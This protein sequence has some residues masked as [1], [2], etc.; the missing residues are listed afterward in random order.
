MLLS[1]LWASGDERTRFMREARAIAG[2]RH[3]H[4]VQVYDVGELDG[5][6]YFTMEFLE[7]GNLRQKQA[8]KPQPA[9]QAA[10]LVALLATAMQV[11]HQS[12]VVHRDL[13]PSNILLTEDGTPKI[14]DFGLARNINAE[15]ED[16]VTQSGVRVGT[17]NYMAPEQALGAHSIGPAA[18]IYALGAILY[19][20]L[21]GR[22]PFQGATSV[23]TISQTLLHEP[24]PP[25]RLIPRLPRDLDTICLK[26]LQKLPE[27]RYLTS[28]DLAADLE[29]FLRDEPI[30]A[31][32]IGKAEKLLRW[33]MRHK[34]IAAA[35]AAVLLLLV[36]IAVGSLIAAGHFKTMGVVQH[37]LA[38]EKGE[39]AEKESRERLKAVE[40]ESRETTLRK[41][42]ESQSEELRHNLYL[43]HM[44][45][46]GQASRAPS[47]IGRI[48]E[49]LAPWQNS[50][51]DL[52]GWEWYYLD[53][54]C[55]RDL[56]TL[57][58]HIGDVIHVCWSPD[59]GR[60]ATSSGDGTVK[61]WNATEGRRLLNIDAHDG[62]AYMVAWSPNGQRLAT[63]GWDRTVKIWDA[64]SGAIQYTF[65]SHAGR[66]FSVAW[67]PDGA[68]LASGDDTGTIL[69]WEAAT[70]KSVAERSAKARNGIGSAIRSSESTR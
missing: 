8:G 13:K 47:G 24:V 25:V 22:P 66:A 27:R 62:A 68:R 65:R 32:P 30:L 18:D 4:I 40:A 26:C 54:L 41:L 31:R 7:G 57:Q 42:A 70:G 43:A 39:L 49:R 2:L 16:G 21:T 34:A 15:E 12:G 61:I 6:P 1:G 23:E 63:A 51:P 52:R 53:S 19:E 33:T 11:A 20:L 67:S 17:P 37:R 48:R 9:R 64:A 5:C 36:T 55:H 10:S 44:N 59:S 58:G 29:R 69:V 35:L 45:L 56:L 60:V 14:T 50:R 3:P 46:G 28:A 38:I